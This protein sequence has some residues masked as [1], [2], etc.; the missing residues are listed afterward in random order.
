MAPAASEDGKTLVELPQ[1]TA[2]Q[3]QACLHVI[4]DRQ[5]VLKD[6]TTRRNCVHV[7]GLAAQ[8]ELQEVYAHAPR[9]A[10]SET[11]QQWAV[12]AIAAGAALPPEA[13]EDV[14]LALLWPLLDQLLMLAVWL[15]QDPG[16]RRDATE[17]LASCVLWSHAR[18][19]QLETALEDV[20]VK[21]SGD[22]AWADVGAC[23][24]EHVFLCLGRAAQQLHQTSPASAVSPAGLPHP[25][26]AAGRLVVAGGHDENWRGL[27]SVE[28]YNP[29]QDRWT[30]GHSLP[31]NMSFATS[32][33][34]GSSMA[35]LEG[36]THNSRMAICHRVEGPWHHLPIGDTA[37][38][39][40]ALDV[41]D[42]NTL[43]V[44]GGFTALAKE[45]AS[46]E[47]ATMW[48]PSSSAADSDPTD[49]PHQLTWRSIAPMPRP[50]VCHSTASIGQSL[51][52]MGGQTSR[53]IYDVIDVWDAGQDSW[54]TLSPALEHTKRKYAT[55]TV[56]DGR[57]IVVGGMSG[58]RQRLNTVAAYDPREGLWQDSA[59]GLPVG[60]PEAP[61]LKRARRGCGWA[62]SD[63]RG[64]VTVQ[65]HGQALHKLLIA[66]TLPGA[67][68]GDLVSLQLLAQRLCVAPLL[69]RQPTSQ[70]RHGGHEYDSSDADDTKV[71][72]LRAASRGAKCAALLA[73]V[74]VL[75]VVRVI[76]RL[77]ASPYARD[78]TMQQPCFGTG[79]H[80]T[81]A[82]L[83][84]STGV[85]R[86]VP[87]GRHLFSSLESQKGG[88]GL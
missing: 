23:S 8:Y 52:L 33:V 54:H 27:R 24:R 77:V 82:T 79:S 75:P 10:T 64:G 37:R 2:A 55:S 21:A 35:V 49:P 85:L 7:V 56:L 44:T 86:G 14:L 16:R 58:S 73:V 53:T 60:A 72:L 30:S 43:V 17:Q 71:H 36:A 63:G 20:E 67:S 31:A 4:Y 87:H 18:T 6:M 51:Y 9:H 61:S 59:G 46:A 70:L 32:A 78:L 11:D 68:P 45:L 84:W 47:A 29:A 19:G 80:L 34:L 25:I 42:G 26:A 81:A 15:D 88:L 3:V 76:R 62:A 65:S 83:P 12:G 5:A 13:L 48:H 40:A 50:R 39:F 38:V 57:I 1:L 22:A 41:I 69:L 74:L 28:V 66:A